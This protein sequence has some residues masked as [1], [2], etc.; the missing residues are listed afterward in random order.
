MREL[1]EERC[2]KCNRLLFKK[3]PVEPEPKI[4]IAKNQIHIMC[5]K[6]KYE[7]KIDV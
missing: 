6:C 3:W 2:K 7:N 5:P 1:T 4:N